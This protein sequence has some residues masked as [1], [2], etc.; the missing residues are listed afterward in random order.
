MIMNIPTEHKNNLIYLLQFLV[1]SKR[2]LIVTKAKEVI[3][4]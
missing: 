1:Y 2:P 3:A 4:T